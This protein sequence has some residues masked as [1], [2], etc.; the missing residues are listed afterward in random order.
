MSDDK[1]ERRRLCSLVGQTISE[2]KVD[3]KGDYVFYFGRGP[4]M[5]VHHDH[6]F[7]GNGMFFECNSHEPPP[8]TPAEEV[9]HFTSKYQRW[10]G[11]DGIPDEPEDSMLDSDE[12]IDIDD[13]DFAPNSS[14]GGF[15]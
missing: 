5:K 7:D 14:E 10:V 11:I 9:E 8:A 15:E 2:I 4:R 6:L 1:Y 3:G 12:L 13:E